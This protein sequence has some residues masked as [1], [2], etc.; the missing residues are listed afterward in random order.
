MGASSIEA[1]TRGQRDHGLSQPL[2]HTGLLRLVLCKFVGKRDPFWGAR[3]FPHQ[4]FQHTLAAQEAIYPKP[5]TRATSCCIRWAGSFASV[6]RNSLHVEIRVLLVCLLWFWTKA[7][8]Q[9]RF[10]LRSCFG[11]SAHGRRRGES[12]WCR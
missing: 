9:T 11:V 12:K 7:G 8:P 4:N 10:I 2:S 6:G 3:R 1:R 5:N